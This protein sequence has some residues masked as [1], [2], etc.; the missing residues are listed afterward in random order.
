MSR[1]GLLK[2]VGFAILLLAGGLQCSPAEAEPTHTAA[3]L[4][5]TTGAGEM[6]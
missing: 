4:I 1:S 2:V 6:S 3:L 5:H